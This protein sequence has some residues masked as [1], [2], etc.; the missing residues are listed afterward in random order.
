MN[1]APLCLAQKF[2]CDY[3]L[4]CA[5]WHRIEPQQGKI[6]QDAVAHYHKIFDCITK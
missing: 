6:D 3:I 1:C 5:E 2:E 4:G